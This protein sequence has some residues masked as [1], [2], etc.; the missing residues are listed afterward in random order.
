M[1]R[2]TLSHL[3]GL[4][5][6]YPCPSVSKFQYGNLESVFGLDVTLEIRP[7]LLPFGLTSEISST[8]YQGL[9][10]KVARVYGVLT[11]NAVYSSSCVQYPKPRISG[12][13]T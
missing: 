7:S 8:P 10:G 11:L 2:L 3:R 13:G 6:K 5:S 4:R 1:S 12:S 9:S